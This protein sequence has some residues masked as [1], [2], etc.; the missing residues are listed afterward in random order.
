MRLWLQGMTVADVAS[1]L[2]VS[3]DTMSELIEEFVAYKLPWGVTALWRIAKLELELDEMS[4]VA[5]ALPAM[6]KY[7]K[8]T[9]EATWAHAA[10][11]SSRNFAT[12]LGERFATE[13]EA[14]DAAA[15][16][17]WLAT[18]QVETL[19][20]EYGVSGQ[21]LR[22]VATAVVRSRPNPLIDELDAGTLLPRQIDVRTPAA[23]CSA[24]FTRTTSGQQ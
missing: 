12:L 2:G 14:S 8:P 17:A 7:G 10:G 11:V 15:F 4:D 24:S 5:D 20:E 13:S 22:E 6:L 9:P 16:S 23:Q 3:T 19:A 21:A 18:Q 1:T